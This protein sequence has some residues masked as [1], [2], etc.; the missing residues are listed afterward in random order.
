MKMKQIMNESVRV[1]IKKFTTRLKYELRLKN[2]IAGKTKKDVS[3]VCFPLGT[4]YPL[5]FGK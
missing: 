2:Y 1:G 3:E 5:S 4:S